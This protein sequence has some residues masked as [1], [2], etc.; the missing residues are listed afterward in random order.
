MEYCGNCSFS[1]K[2]PV[3]RIEEIQ[4]PHHPLT[5]IDRQI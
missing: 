5:E 2:G 1:M 4:M 3:V